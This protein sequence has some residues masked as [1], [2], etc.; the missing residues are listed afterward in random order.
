MFALA[1]RLKYMVIP[2]NAYLVYFLNEMRRR[3]RRTTYLKS[4]NLCWWIMDILILKPQTPATSSENISFRGPSA[5]LR[6]TPL[7]YYYNASLLLLI[8]LITGTYIH[9]HNMLRIN[10]YMYKLHTVQQC[11]VSSRLRIYLTHKYFR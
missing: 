10:K 5:S 3:D 2:N 9:I 8:N 6:K 11:S 7:Y 4:W 1:P